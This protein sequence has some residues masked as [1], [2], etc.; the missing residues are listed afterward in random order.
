MMFSAAS[1]LVMP[2]WLLLVFLPR[3]RWTTA[4]ITSCLLPGLLAIAYLTLFAT[5]LGSMPEGFASFNS[6]AG[7]KLLFESD[8][9]LLA[10]WIHY[11]AFDLFIGSW[12]VRDAQRLGIHHLLVIPCLVLTLMLGPIGLLTYLVLRLVARRRWSGRV[13]MIASLVGAI[14]ALIFVQRLPVFGSLSTSVGVV[15]A[16]TAFLVC[17][18]QGYRAIRRREIAR[19]REWMIRTFAIGLGISTFRVLMP[20]LMIPPVSATLPE[21]WDTVVWLGFAINAIVAEVWINVTRRRSPLTLHTKS[22]LL[23]PVA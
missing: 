16:G 20:L 8:A 5:N 4:F 10:G 3:W 7:V 23:R 14:S 21:A 9:L 22:Q 13:W 12:Q 1:T 18:V 17:L 6:L 15:F 11:L 2:G 19:H